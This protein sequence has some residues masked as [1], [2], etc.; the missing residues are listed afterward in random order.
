MKTNVN[1]KHKRLFVN[2]KGQSVVEFAILL[3]VMLLMLLGLMEWG[4]LLWT[5]TTYVNAV[6]EGS[7]DAVVIR[8]W[9]SNYTTRAAEVKAIVIGRLRGLPTTLTTG[10]ADHIII[11]LL[12]SQ[13]HIDSIRISIANQPYASIIGFADV[14]VPQTLSATSEFRYE[15]NL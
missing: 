4:F 2:N 12:P 14:V 8:D 11:E 1:T 7:R 9:D 10:I 13:S 5:Q 6:R 15:G 3:P